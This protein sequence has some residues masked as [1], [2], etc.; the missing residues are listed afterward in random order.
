MTIV[1]HT[2]SFT[3]FFFW[4]YIIRRLS[5]DALEL[6]AA[7]CYFSATDLRI[8]NLY[9]L[10]FTSETHF[11]AKVE[12]VQLCRNFFPSRFWQQSVAP[13][14]TVYCPSQHTRTGPVWYLSG[15]TGW[16]GCGILQRERH[17]TRQSTP[18]SLL[19]TTRIIRQS[20]TWL[21]HI[22]LMD[23][24]LRYMPMLMP[25]IPLKQ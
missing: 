4:K 23:Y 11:I 13:S 9:L 14:F 21:F 25:L 12:T 16:A 19:R 20:S 24:F 8:G 15:L 6:F 7:R 3:L 17:G 18:A 1:F 2:R 5:V 22:H 10:T